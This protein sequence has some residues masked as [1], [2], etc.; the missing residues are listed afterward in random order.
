MN[1]AAEDIERAARTL[2]NFHIVYDEPV[3]CDAIVGLGSYDLRVADRCAELYHAGVARAVVLTGRSGNWTAGLYHGTEAEAFAARC[4]DLG[5]PDSAIL[6]EPTAT[7]IGENIRYTAALVGGW[8]KKILIVTKPQTQRRALATAIRQWPAAEIRV[9][10]PPTAFEDQATPHHP[11]EKL[12]DE[13]VGDI[14]RLID[15]P[16]KGYCA[17][18]EIPADVMEAWRFL[19]A[20]GFERHL[21]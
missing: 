7:N 4:R 1:A 20:Q 9:T 3:P 6:I 16:A 17:E 21:G 12:V 5:V 14:K 10:A 2:W 15:Y 18:V 19:L 13:M 11:F 8:A